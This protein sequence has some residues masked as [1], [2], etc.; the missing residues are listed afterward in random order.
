MRIK[1]A[2]GIIF[3][4][5]CYVAVAYLMYATRSTCQGLGICS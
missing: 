4:A 3:M 5:S 1:A 2:L